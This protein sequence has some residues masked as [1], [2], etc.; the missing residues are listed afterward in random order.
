MKKKQKKHANLRALDRGIVKRG[1]KLRS[2]S[3]ENHKQGFEQLLDDAI[4]GVKKK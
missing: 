4:F 1:T 2:K 3:V